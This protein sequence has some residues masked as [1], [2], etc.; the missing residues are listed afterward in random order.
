MLAVAGTLLEAESQVK[1]DDREKFLAG[2]CPPL[3]LP[4]SKDELTVRWQVRH[5][6][7][8]QTDRL[9]K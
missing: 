3:E 4:Y 1:S 7:T 9:E 5:G 2:K 8:D 6:G